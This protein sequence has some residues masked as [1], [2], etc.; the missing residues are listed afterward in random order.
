MRAVIV[1]HEASARSE[2]VQLCEQ[3]GVEVVAQA[4]SGASGIE[5]I[6]AHGPDLVLLEAELKDM[7][8]FELL[9]TSEVYRQ[10]VM[11]IMVTA[12]RQHARL[13]LECRAIDFLTKPIERERFL[14]AIARVRR[15]L[16]RMHYERQGDGNGSSLSRRAN[17][18]SRCASL[19]RRHGDCT[20]WRPPP[21]ITSS[22]M[23]TTSPF[24][25]V[26]SAM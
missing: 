12:Q 21:L 3:A 26:P 22:P 2:L 15:E 17:G 10:D 6:R 11:A 13:A 5:V 16:G 14:S 4:D 7:S 1:D 19:R 23:V 24:T 9:R 20:S 25:W 8:G 18:S